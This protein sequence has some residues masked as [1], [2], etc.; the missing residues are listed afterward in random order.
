MQQPLPFKMKPT[1]V[2]VTDAFIQHT[3][4]DWL[5]IMQEYGHEFYPEYYGYGYVLHDPTACLARYWLDYL[6]PFHT[7]TSAEGMKWQNMYSP[8]KS[9]HHLI[10][11]REAVHEF[12]T[13]LRQSEVQVSKADTLH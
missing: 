8:H 7:D 1:T 11:A 13:E 9:M 10:L 5:G 6:T 2:H 3:P 4:Q 12:F